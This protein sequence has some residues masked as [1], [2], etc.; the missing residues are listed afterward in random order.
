MIDTEI[1]S[2]NP[3]WAN[4]LALLLIS[5]LPAC[6]Q[7][8]TTEV[9]GD[10]AAAR[11]KRPNILLIVADDLG[12]SDLGVYGGEI[13][14]PTLDQ[15][16]KNGGLQL[17]NFNAGPTCS[18]TRSMILSGTY[19]HQAGQGAMTEWMADNQR[20]QPGYEGYLSDRIAALPELMS[21]AGYYTFMAGKWHLGMRSDHWPDARGFEDSFAMLPGA[22]NHFS[23]KGLNPHLPVVP[24]VENGKPANLPDD[25]YSTRFYTDKVIEYL[26]KASGSSEP[27][28]GYVAYTAPHWPL[29]VPEEYS[30]KYRG[31]YSAGY[32]AIRNERLKKMVDAGLFPQDMPVNSLSE[33]RVLWDDLSA[34]EQ[35]RQA[36]D[37]EIYA[38]MVDALDE[39]IGRLLGHLEQIGERENTMVIF[40]SDNGADARPE[41]GLGGESRFISEHYNN[42]LN[43]L[44]TESS[45]V[46]Y[47]GAWA[48]VASTP[49]SLHK[50]MTTEGGIRVPAIISFPRVAVISGT[51]NEFMSVMDLL[52]TFLD[53][54]GAKHPDGMYHGRE[55]LP[56]AGKTVLPFLE[57]KADKVHETPLYG[58]SVHRRQGF[59]YGD[60]K[61]VRL[62]MPEGNG[63]WQ[64]F[65]LGSDPGETENLAAS[66]PE[67]LDDMVARW[68]AFASQTG[69]IVSEPG[70]GRPNECT[71][72]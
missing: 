24:Y 34:E 30:D 46:S 33:C 56:M 41:K 20:D 72:K 62:P 59:Q 43:N 50:G 27:F 68:E 64:L 39:N 37:M 31:R 11:A 19:N 57:G 14:T 9:D 54:A 28:F 12:F 36:R 2:N 5:H 49:F 13:S 51:S 45:F 53:I 23:D 3:V 32:Q 15:L 71:G 69:V 48:E 17:T 8:V 44:G 40:I 6:G 22:G 35:A 38:G 10:G 70:A 60:L 67:T 18:P 1:K 21:D 55:V 58:F 52:P 47:G 16:A 66:M 42:S 25:F 65:D 4:I 63:E 61:L 7:S 29:Q 26:N